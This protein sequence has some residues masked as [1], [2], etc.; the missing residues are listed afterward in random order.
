MLA[1]YVFPDEN[2]KPLRMCRMQSTKQAVA[3]LSL[4]TGNETLQNRNRHWTRDRFLVPYCWRQ[5][6]RLQQLEN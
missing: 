6:K 5:I 2:Q 4:I 3:I 1:S